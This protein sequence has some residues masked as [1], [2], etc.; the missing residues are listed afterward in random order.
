MYSCS[1][2]HHRQLPRDSGGLFD[3]T[4]QTCSLT[5]QQVRQLAGVEMRKRVSQNAGDLWIQV[6]QADREQIKVELPKL[7]LNEPQ[8]VLSSPQITHNLT[9]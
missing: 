1:R 4:R 8:Y 5:F 6:P 3:R 2:T 7:V 9:K